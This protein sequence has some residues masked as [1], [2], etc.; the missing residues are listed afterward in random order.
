MGV[1]VGDG[2]VNTAAFDQGGLEDMQ[3]Q[4]DEGLK[5]APSIA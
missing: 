2:R 5:Q 4:L 3:V 1:N